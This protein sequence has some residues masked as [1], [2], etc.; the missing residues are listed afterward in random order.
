MLVLWVKGCL[1]R[2]GTIVG[3]NYLFDISQVAFSVSPEQAFVICL[4]S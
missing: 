1:G 4:N 3:E 2:M